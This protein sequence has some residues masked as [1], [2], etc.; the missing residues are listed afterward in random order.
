LR[1]ES[2]LVG[3]ALEPVGFVDFVAERLTGS[4]LAEIFEN[5]FVS[6]FE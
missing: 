6:A 3:C 5:N 4:E 2:I 1:D